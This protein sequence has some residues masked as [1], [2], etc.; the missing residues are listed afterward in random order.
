VAATAASEATQVFPLRLL[1]PH[2][3]LVGIATTV[4]ETSADGPGRRFLQPAVILG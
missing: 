2:G 1:D 3:R 4:D